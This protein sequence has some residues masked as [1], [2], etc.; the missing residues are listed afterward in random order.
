MLTFQCI[1]AIN[2]GF[3]NLRVIEGSRVSSVDSNC[4]VLFADKKT[5]ITLRLNRAVYIFDREVSVELSHFV[6]FVTRAYLYSI[7]A[8]VVCFS[9]WPK[10]NIQ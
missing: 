10:H 1:L 2:H 5:D 8:F 3:G 7:T 4:C 6:M 9:P